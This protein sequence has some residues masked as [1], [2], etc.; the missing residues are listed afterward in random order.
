MKCFINTISISEFIPANHIVTGSVLGDGEFGSVLKGTY[1][2]HPGISMPVAVKT[3]HSQ[4]LETNK[5][6]FLR[7]AR[8]MMGL[9]HL[10]IV[11]LIGISMVV[12][13][14]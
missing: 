7:E 1:N 13:N 5:L 11:R 8:V 4:H 9:N 2:P 12:I 10:C 3:L 6:E 14:H